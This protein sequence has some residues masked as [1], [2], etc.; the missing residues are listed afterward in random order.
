MAIRI[1]VSWIEKDGY[2]IEETKTFVSCS[3]YTDHP[4][5]KIQAVVN[6]FKKDLPDRREDFKVLSI[7]VLW[8]DFFISKNDGKL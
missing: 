2:G 1:N 3:I 7:N 8:G 4:I 5:D 6:K